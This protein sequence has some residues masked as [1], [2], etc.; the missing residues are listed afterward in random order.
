GT[1][2]Q[3]AVERL[4]RAFDTQATH[5][6]AGERADDEGDD[7]VHT[8]QAQYQHDGDRGNYCIHFMT[9]RNQTKLALRRQTASAVAERQVFLWEGAHSE[10]APATCQ[11]TGLDGC[12]RVACMT[13]ND[14]FQLN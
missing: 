10:A 2:T 9:S 11:S 12:T 5:Q 13:E 4:E 6:A 14:A 3:A 8:G 1:A 7:H